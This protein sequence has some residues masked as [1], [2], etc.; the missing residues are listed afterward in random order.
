MVVI[1]PSDPA[2]VGRHYIGIEINPA[3]C[4]LAEGRIQ[5]AARKRRDTAREKSS[6][7]GYAS[8]DKTAPAPS[9]AATGARKETLP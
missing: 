2:P 7:D 3:F 8:R 1:D 4:K 5:T 6:A 9:V